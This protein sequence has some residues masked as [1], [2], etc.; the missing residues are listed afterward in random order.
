M[1]TKFT[2]CHLYTQMM[3]GCIFTSFEM[4][5]VKRNLLFFAEGNTELLI[6]I[7]LIATQMEVTMNCFNRIS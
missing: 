6:T 2:S 7:S 5:E 1:I 3:Q 4:N